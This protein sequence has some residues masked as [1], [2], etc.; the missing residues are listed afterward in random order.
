MLNLLL[1]IHIIV[2]VKFSSVG[3]C[4]CFM[5]LYTYLSKLLP[6]TSKNI[7]LKTRSQ[8]LKVKNCEIINMNFLETLNKSDSTLILSDKTDS[9][10]LDK[11][12]QLGSSWKLC[13][14]S[15]ISGVTNDSYQVILSLLPET[16]YNEELLTKLLSILK[17]NG[18]FICSN[19]SDKDKI[20]FLLK[21]NGFVNV[22]KE[23][24][25]VTSLKPKYEIGSS[26]KLNIKKPAATVWK[27][28]NNDDEDVETI[29]PD[30]LLDEEDLKKPDPSSLKVCGTT[31]KRKACKDCS[32]GLAEELEQEAREGKVVDTTNAPKSSCG[33]C[34][35]GDAFR[36]AS[37]PYL[38][39]PAFKPGE[40]IQLAGN[41][42]QPDIL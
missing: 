12:L 18:K 8:C 24:S 36:C 34:Y 1:S 19:I 42:L 2:W 11:A 14:H 25:D 4:L 27:L 41:Q 37:C 38:G 28:D 3:G 16:L 26:A 21:T 39:M 6:L 9:S 10:E 31:G 22:T 40:K 5:Y 7:S 13:S 30:N 17:P 32:C 33:S 35:L 23:G 29:D 15:E 20:D